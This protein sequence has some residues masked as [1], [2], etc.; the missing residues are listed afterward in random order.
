MIGPKIT[1]AVPTLTEGKDGIMF[2]HEGN[3]SEMSVMVPALCSWRPEYRWAP[4][5]RTI[6]L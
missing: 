6:N 2:L 5:L 1:A 3:I 4:D